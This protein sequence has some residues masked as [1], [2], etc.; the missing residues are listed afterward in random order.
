MDTASSLTGNIQ[1]RQSLPVA[2]AL[3]ILRGLQPSHAVVDGR[4]DNSNIERLLGK[5]SAGDHIVVEL[6]ANTGLSR[7]LIMRLPAWVGVPLAALRVGLLL[8]RCLVM[9]LV[10]SSQFLHRH[11]HVLSKSLTTLVVLHDTTASVV[12]AV[13]NDFIGR[14]LVQAKAERGL[15]LPHLAGDIIAPTQLVGESVAFSIQEQ[16]TDSTQSFRS[17]ELNLCVRIIHLDQSS[18]VN[19]NPLKIERVR[20]NV[21]THFDTIT[22]AMLA[23]G[24]GQVHQIRAI[25]GKQGITGKIRAKPTTAHNHGP[26]LSQGL[27]SLDILDTNDGLFVHDQLRCARLRDN[28]GHGATRILGNLLHHLDESVGDCHPRKTLLA[29]VSPFGRVATKSCYE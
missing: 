23:I 14:S 25:L 28:P 8:L 3:T 13:P 17:E 15:V 1:S 21:F 4:R 26:K 27:S 11:T 18:R 29:S 9:L 20:A 2:H 22:G 7:G 5:L 12:L 19:L 24:G 16:P 10:S 6:L